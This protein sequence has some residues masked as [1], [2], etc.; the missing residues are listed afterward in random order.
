MEK[1][2]KGLRRKKR[3]EW[4]KQ[5]GKLRKKIKKCRGRE[6]NVTGLIV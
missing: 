4:V 6:K 2:D 1:G 5:L 3:S